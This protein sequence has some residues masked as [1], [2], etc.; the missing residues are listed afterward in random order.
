MVTGDVNTLP[1]IN[2]HADNNEVILCSDVVFTYIVELPTYIVSVVE[3][4]HCDDDTFTW[5]D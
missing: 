5:R 4:S 1:S 2:D 3:H